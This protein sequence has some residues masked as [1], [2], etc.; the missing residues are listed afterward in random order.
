MLIAVTF[1]RPHRN[2]NA[3][4]AAAALSRVRKSVLC[5]FA[6]KLCCSKSLSRPFVGLPTKVC[7]ALGALLLGASLSDAQ[8][9]VERTVRTATLKS[10]LP[11]PKGAKPAPAKSAKGKAKPK[12]AAAVRV[13]PVVA[14][15]PAAAALPLADPA[16]AAKPPEATAAA[17][18]GA[19]MTMET[20]LDRLMMAESAGRLDA[21]NPR[22]TALGPFQFIESTFLVVAKR[23]F[24]TET[25][26]M[27][28]Q[29]ILAL[30]TDAAFSRRAA[31]AYT[32]ENAAVLKASDVEPSYPNLR[33]AFL[34]GPGGAIKV[35]KAPPEMPRSGVL[36]PAVLIANPFM[37]TMTSRGLAARSAREVNQPVTSRQGVDVPP[38][39]ALPRRPSTPAIAVTCN[40]KL[41]SCKRWLSL[42]QA[43]LRGNKKA[44]PRTTV[45]S[46]TVPLAANAARLGAG[47]IATPTKGALRR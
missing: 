19:P 43:K 11:T 23:Y 30:R 33:L 5:G 37:V 14:A 22:S 6:I 46:R 13:A 41:P 9:Q 20:F 12:Q 4:P 40:L 18:D 35:L 34:L 25:A 29:Q 42:Q 24:A 3:R 7:L 8:A 36:S 27:T 1:P 45:A 2:L 10:A 17:P 39:T 32:R 47:P 15:V 16:A 44:A 28:P 26:A 21:R 31:E 38:G